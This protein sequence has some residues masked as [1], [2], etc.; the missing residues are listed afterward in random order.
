MLWH[1]RHIKYICYTEKCICIKVNYVIYILYIY[2]YIL[3]SYMLYIHMYAKFPAI[4]YFKELK[5]LSLL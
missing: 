5:L 1:V 4:A 3:D 2:I